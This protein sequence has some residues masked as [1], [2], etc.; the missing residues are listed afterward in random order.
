[1][2]DDLP[3]VWL[4][5]FRCCCDLRFFATTD[6][7][8]LNEWDK[9]FWEIDCA[10]R[11]RERERESVQVGKRRCLKSRLRERLSEKERESERTTRNERERKKGGERERGVSK[12]LEMREE[13]SV[14]DL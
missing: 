10:F 2:S 12:R 5:T 3:E 13:E 4:N 7:G 9:I 6:D 11:E 1:M 8:R 14:S